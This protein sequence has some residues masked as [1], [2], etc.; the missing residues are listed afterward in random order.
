[1]G[2]FAHKADWYDT[3]NVNYAQSEAQSVSVFVHHLSNEPVDAPQL[4]SNGRGR[5]NGSSY[6]D[7]VIYLYCNPFESTVNCGIIFAI[8]IY[9]CQTLSAE[10]SVSP[11]L[12]AYGE[13]Y[14]W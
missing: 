11:C 5:E 6:V 9:E 12:G 7:M 1:M 10:G 13:L 3:H 8:F 4:D 2:W 14:C